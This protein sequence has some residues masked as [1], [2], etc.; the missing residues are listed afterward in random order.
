MNEVEKRE[1]NYLL[2]RELEELI[3][4]LDDP[5]IDQ[6]VKQALQERYQVVFQLFKRIA[7]KQEFIKYIPK[8]M[9]Y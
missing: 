3:M 1:M 7:N 2:K 8:R 5:R 9:D 4:D 6:N